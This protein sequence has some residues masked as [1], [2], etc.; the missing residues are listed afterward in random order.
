MPA[1]NILET[2]LSIDARETPDG[3]VVR[4]TVQ[5]LARTATWDDLPWLAARRPL[6][7]IVELRNLDPMPTSSLV[8]WLLRVA[9]ELPQRAIH[10]RAD[11]R[12][13]TTLRLLGI[14]RMLAHRLV[15]SET[16]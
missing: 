5:A 1:L 16:V 3:L 9:E 6:P 11:Q 8:R 10:L 7:V 4:P 12:V 14:D 13:M 2:M 15:Q